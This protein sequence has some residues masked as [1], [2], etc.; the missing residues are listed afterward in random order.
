MNIKEN[1]GSIINVG[2]GDIVSSKTKVNISIKQIRTETIIISFIVGFL[3]SLLA[4]W[5]FE[6]F[7]Q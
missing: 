5:L 6:L 1:D 2:N 4:S 3:S 7:K